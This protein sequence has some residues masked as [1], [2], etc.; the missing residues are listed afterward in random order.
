MKIHTSL[1]RKV[2][3]V[4]KL[5]ACFGVLSLLFFTPASAQSL[6]GVWSTT[7]RVGY[8]GNG[9]SFIRF[10]PNGAVQLE[11]AS[12]D[13]QGGA[14]AMRRCQGTYQFNGQMVAMQWASCQDCNGFGCYFSNTSMVSTWLRGPFYVRYIDSQTVDIGNQVYHRQQ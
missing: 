5:W 1:L 7:F 9:V 12:A 3:K 2:P 11:M 8:T 14:S 13:S 4:R 6:V 10:S